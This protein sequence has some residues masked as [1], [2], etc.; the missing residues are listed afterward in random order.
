MVGLMVW[1]GVVTVHEQ[2]RAKSVF[3]ILWLGSIG[4]SIQMGKYFTMVM[5]RK[6]GFKEVYYFTCFLTLSCRTTR[7]IIYLPCLYSLQFPLSVC[8][9]STPI[10]SV[11]C[12]LSFSHSRL[13]SHIFIVMSGNWEL[14]RVVFCSRPVVVPPLWI[15]TCFSFELWIDLLYP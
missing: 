5:T 10:D 9:S 14:R 7:P 11:V 4:G 1:K 12:C 15:L 2:E 6:A 13:L 3:S 8:D